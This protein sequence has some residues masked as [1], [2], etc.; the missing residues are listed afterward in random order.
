MASGFRI[1]ASTG[2]DQGDR[3]YQ[4]DQL[5]LTAHSRARGCLLGVIADGMGGRSGG[6]KASDQVM[7]TAQQLFERYD[8]KTDDAL[9][10]LERIARESHTVIK[11]TAVSAEQ[12]PHSTIAAFLVNPDGRCFFA[13]SGDS[14]LYLYRQGTLIHRTRDHSYIQSM[15]ER[16]QMS[17]EEAAF[18]PRSNLLLHC[19]GTVNDPAVALDDVGMLMAGDVIVACSDGVWHYY[20]NAEMGH[21][22]SQLPPRDA[23]EFLIH[24]ARQRAD[25]RG[26]NLSLIIVRLDPL[27]TNTGK[28]VG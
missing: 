27:P 24:K 7:L 28:R 17:E 3:D 21:V 6:R 14:R 23:C 10:L 11:L 9:A 13:H 18:D 19:L 2:L 25:G 15:V 22:V 1:V 5:Q 20:T 8:P 12:E 4:Q 16:G 26:D